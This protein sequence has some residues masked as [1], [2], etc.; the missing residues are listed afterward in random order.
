[1]FY[2]MGYCL[3]CYIYIHLRRKCVMCCWVEYS[4]TVDEIQLVNGIVQFFHIIVDFLS[5]CYTDHQGRRTAVSTCKCG[6][7][8]FSFQIYQLL[9]HVFYG[10]VVRCIDTSY[11]PFYHYVMTFIPEEFSCSEDY[12]I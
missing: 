12:F 3:F 8:C 5:I 4:I 11:R 7:V 2:D 9:L 10:Y 1:M 6:F